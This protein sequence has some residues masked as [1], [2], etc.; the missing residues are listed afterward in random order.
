ML[1]MNKKLLK[2]LALIMCIVM[3]FSV[4][5][6]KVNVKAKST[7]Y[8]SSTNMELTKGKKTRLRLKNA[9]KGAKITWKTTN[10]YAVVVSKKGTVR[11]VNAGNA[12]IYV[13]CKNKTYSCKIN[14]PDSDRQIELNSQNVTL[15]E[16]NTFQLVAETNRKVTYISENNN[17]ATVD[18]NG[19][20]TAVNPG[21]V[22]I[23][24]KTATAFSK[25][26]VQVQSADEQV[27]SP[28][29]IYNKSA[30]GIRRITKRGTVIYD[31]ICWVSNKAISF[32]IDNINE[33]NIKKCVWSSS[34]ETV[35]SKPQKRDGSLITTDANT[36]KA[37]TAIVTAK[38]TNKSGKVSKYTSYVFVTTPA[39]DKSELKLYGN[40]VGNNRQ[41]YVTFTGLNKFSTISVSN[42][43]EKA[44]S[45]Q[46]F[47]DKM[48]VTGLSEGSGTITVTIDGKA[49]KIK[50]VTYNPVIICG[51]A[52]IQKKKTTKIT[53]SGAEG[54]TPQYTSRNRKIATVKSDGTVKGVR[55][56]VTYI[57]VKLGD[58]TKSFRIEVSA[59]GMQTIIDRANYIVN[60]WK[61]SQAKRMKSG[62]YDCSALVWKGY[63][64]YNNYQKKLGS[65][66]WAY[67]AGELFDYLYS[68][69][70]IVYFGYTGT[71]GMKPGDLIFYGD[72]NNAVKYSTPGRT[73]DIYHVAMYA[74][75]GQVVEKGGQTMNSNN[76]KYI[77]GI[78]RVVN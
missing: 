57:D 18:N 49:I 65:S 2:C 42:S 75:N 5:L 16:N 73:L 14:V 78:G 60:H 33:D 51:A 76:T 68:K 28:D 77:V 20:I 72:Y 3:S 22:T 31:N 50:Y 47:H 58:Y 25:C 10:K 63:K 13:K 9:P 23:T 21:T 62:Y 41:Q 6:P 46:T 27:I 11:A 48:A 74:G 24:A 59:T 29:W 15:V 55:S 12:T 71:D 67:S 52:A 1:R 69:N 37:G 26:T 17:I 56:G 34:D 53:V 54:I 32:K 45:V 7:V 19:L 61:Y 70:Q 8:L 44:A 35:L 36:L 4:Y 38:V 66:K 39:S 43:N 64:A 40:G 30:T